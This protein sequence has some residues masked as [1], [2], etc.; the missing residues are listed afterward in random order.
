MTSR[1]VFVAF[2]DHDGIYIYFFQGATVGVT[3]GI[4]LSMYIVFRAQAA[5]TSGE[6]VHE[7]KPTS[8]EGC[9]YIFDINNSSFLTMTPTPTHDANE[10]FQLHRISYFYFAALASATTVIVAFIATLIFR[11]SDPNTVD[12]KLLAPFMRK[13]FQSNFPPV[14]EVRL[15]MTQHLFDVKDNK[16]VVED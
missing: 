10:S 16:L 5:Q 6:L 14:E 15:E 4:I 13:Y 2:R 7:T 11:D 3:A 1:C 12:P 9:S 8:I